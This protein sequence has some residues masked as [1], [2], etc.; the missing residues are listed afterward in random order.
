MP[1]RRDET[2][3]G[4]SGFLVVTAEGDGA[5][6]GPTG[7][8]EPEP[9]AGLGVG[10][11]AGGALGAGVPGVGDPVAGEPGD[12]PPESG[13]EPGPPAARAPFEV[14]VRGS[15]DATIS[16]KPV[17]APGRRTRL[18]TAREGAAATSAGTVRIWEPC[19][20]S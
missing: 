2:G 6:A 17:N 10:G 3:R 5:A 19:R 7:S 15:L 1:R 8:P 20:P 4:R 16:E 9:L 11:W 12:R 13:E 18:G 14:L